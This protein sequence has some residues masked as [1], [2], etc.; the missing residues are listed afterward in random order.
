MLI[1][2]HIHFQVASRRVFQ[3]CGAFLLLM[4]VITKVGAIM[5]LIP[6]PVI[7]GINTVLLGTMISVGVA[8][9][10][11]VDMTS[12]RNQAVLGVTFILGLAAPQYVNANPDAIDTGIQT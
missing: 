6:D 9:L 12:S 8:T 5:T 7:G 11:H 3:M 2:L 1:Q 4:G 10:S